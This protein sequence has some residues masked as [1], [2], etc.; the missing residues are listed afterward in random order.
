MLAATET[1]APNILL[2]MTDQQRADALG[3]SGGWVPTPHLDGLAAEGMRFTNCITTSPVCIPARLSLATGL[4]PHHTGVW[5]NQRSQPSGQ[6]PTWMQRVRSAGYRTSLF[7]KSHLHPHQGDLRDREDLMRAYGLDDV[8]EIGGPRASARVLSHMTATWEAA[9]VWQAYRADYEERFRDKPHMVRPS[10]LGLGHY[11]D[12]YVGQ[13]ARQYIADYDLDKPWCCWV[14]FGGPHEPWDA[15]EPFASLC[16]PAAMPAAR[17]VPEGAAGR[18]LGELDRMLESAPNPAPEEIA[19]M[20]ANYAGNIALIDEQVGDIFAAIKERGEWENTVVVLV[21]D[22]GEMNGDAGLIYKSNFL[23]GALRVPL[24]V[25]TPGM[26]GGA[27]SDALVEW[28]DIGPTLIELAGGVVDY[29]QFARSLYP[30]LESPQIEHRPT[31]IAELAG[32]IMLL[33][34]EW[35]AALNSAGQ[36]YLLFDVQNDP[37][38]EM[39]LAGRPEMAPVE[40]ALR[41]RLLEHLVSTQLQGAVYR[42]DLHGN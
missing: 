8:D 30:V 4:Y 20:R 34:R 36:L 37:E 2:L 26:V 42:C 9:G 17:R 40:D 13:R 32:E 23:D 38:E 22:H 28:I 14:S 29:P 1:G 33:D 19:A 18:P 12:V 5:Q 27:V 41:L 21:S 11:A 31:A 39:N 35:K 3:T 15:P 16:D 24:V 6:Q 25:R 7:G 10:P